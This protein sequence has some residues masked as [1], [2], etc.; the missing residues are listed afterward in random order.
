MLNYANHGEGGAN[1][2]AAFIPGSGA[3]IHHPPTT[4]P[5][6]RPPQLQPPSAQSSNSATSTPIVPPPQLQQQLAGGP[7]APPHMLLLTPVA[8]TPPGGADHLDSS[9]YTCTPAEGSSACQQQ[10][11][12]SGVNTLNYTTDTEAPVKQGGGVS[13]PGTPLATP[14]P[15]PGGPR[16]AMPPPM[17]KPSRARQR[18]FIPATKT[19]LPTAKKLSY[20]SPC[21]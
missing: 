15:C 19:P 5:V 7:V 14:S 21:E 13:A 4:S 6:L 9:Y 3:A 20:F 18:A 11:A 8:A 12:M 1:P 16:A 10:S 2:P 17:I